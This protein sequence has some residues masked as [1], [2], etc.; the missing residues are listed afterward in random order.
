M[1][2]VAESTSNGT[3]N[4]PIASS[5]TQRDLD[6]EQRYHLALQRLVQR[7]AFGTGTVAGLRVIGELD[8]TTLPLGVFLEAGL[9][10]DPNGREL[11]VEK[12]VSVDVAAFPLAASPVAFPGPPTNRTTLASAVVTRFGGSLGFDVNDL[13]QLALELYTAGLLTKA[14]YDNYLASASNISDVMAQLALI[15]QIT[16]TLTPPQVLESWLFEQL[17]GV[18]YLGLRYREVGT[19]PA[20]VVLNSSCCGS[21]PCS[22]TRTLE[23]VYLVAADAPFGEPDD[24]YHQKQLCL[25]AQ[26]FAQLDAAPSLPSQVDA[27][28]ALCECLL[29][30]WSGL[31]P[32]GNSCTEDATPVVPLA[33]VSWARF[34]QSGDTQILGIDNCDRRPL[35]PGAPALRALLDSLTAWSTPV[36]LPPRIVSISPAQDALVPSGSTPGGLALSAVANAQL[37]MATGSTLAN[38]WEIAFHPAGGGAPQLFNNGSGGPSGTTVSISIVTP[39]PTVGHE[40]RIT[41]SGGSAFAPGTYVWRLLNVAGSSEVVSN[42]TGAQLDGT[43]DPLT[44]APSG[45]G[46]SGGAFEAR[47]VVTP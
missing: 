41:F 16:P 17:V 43:P 22:P 30:A 8:A 46:I 29:G 7:E 5:L 27:R 28:A 35:A 12:A 2:L 25:E 47:F 23:G 13:N 33:T 3:Q 26:L 1:S 37:K 11:L 21:V 36:K 10:I 18:T 40:I 34:Q 9:A 19:D 20:P 38:L 42:A 14:Q 24:G 32:V 31:P 4:Y 6:A 39:G 15:P 44:A 45:D